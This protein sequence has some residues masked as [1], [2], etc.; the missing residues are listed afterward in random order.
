MFAKLGKVLGRNKGSLKIGSIDDSNKR[1]KDQNGLDASALKSSS[2]SK[3]ENHRNDTKTISNSANSFKTSSIGS[4]SS[5][6]S[7]NLSSSSLVRTSQP[8]FINHNNSPDEAV[9][10]QERLEGQM[11]LQIQIKHLDDKE[12]NLTIERKVPIYDVLV[13]VANQF[14][15]NPSDFYLRINIDDQDSSLLLKQKWKSNPVGFLNTNKIFIVPKRKE[16]MKRDDYFHHQQLPKGLPFKPTVRF[17]VNLPHNQLMVMRIVPSLSFEEIKKKICQE[18]SF[19]PNRYVLVKSFKSG[20]SLLLLDLD[21]NPEY[22]GINDC[23]ILSLRAYNESTKQFSVNSHFQQHHFSSLN[24]DDQNDPHSNRLNVQNDWSQ[25]TPNI[26]LKRQQ[27]DSCSLVSSSRL[28]NLKINYR[29]KSRAPLPPRYSSS[30]SCAKSIQNLAV[31]SDENETDVNNSTMINSQTSSETFALHNSSNENTAEKV[32]ISVSAK[33][34]LQLERHQ[35]IDNERQVR[36]NRLSRQNSGSDSSGYH[37]MLSSGDTDTPTE[38]N[39]PAPPVSPNSPSLDSDISSIEPC[40]NL[41]QPGLGLVNETVVSKEYAKQSLN[42]HTRPP[43]I[44]CHQSTKINQRSKKR[45]APSPPS[46]SK[47]PQV[48]KQLIMEENKEENS[49]LPSDLAQNIVPETIAQETSVKETKVND[50]RDSNSTSIRSIESVDANQTSSENNVHSI[51]SDQ[52]LIVTNQNLHRLECESQTES[53]QTENVISIRNDSRCSQTSKQECL[54]PVQCNI[55]IDSNENV[56]EESSTPIVSNDSIEDQQTM[57]IRFDYENLI[58]SQQSFCPTETTEMVTI[59]NDQ[60]DYE[61]T[62]S[63]C[64]EKNDENFIDDEVKFDEKERN[65]TESILEH[66]NQIIHAKQRHWFSLLDGDLEDVS[67][68]TIQIENEDSGTEFE[69]DETL[70]EEIYNTIR[71]DQ[72]NLNDNDN[73][74]NVHDDDDVHDE[75]D[76]ATD[77]IHSDETFDEHHHCSY[78]QN[79]VTNFDRIRAKFNR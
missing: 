27:S 37:E 40:N 42:L 32:L 21:K 24:I 47:N 22:Y 38:S 54:D 12:I 56:C 14:R 15:F 43:K 50:H 63:H 35:T 20:Q 13:T 29:K 4:Y 34:N 3:I 7:S 59:D 66:L 65:E 23:T 70:V 46:C 33:Q 76:D 11:N 16:S 57:E 49:S 26:A 74:G 44:V 1:I 25:S 61:S 6:S 75:I 72:T 31:I 69:V 28:S 48:S 41:P 2:K 45:R 62:K 67:I 36:R 64:S 60:S 19:D 73:D 5:S 71:F 77:H 78:C 52:N 58:V 9:S 17:Q 51:T 68:T 39:S 30:I 18:K 55:D 10:V 8:L 53:N 79:Y